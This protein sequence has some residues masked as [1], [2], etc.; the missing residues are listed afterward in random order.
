MVF[1]RTK[2]VTYVTEQMINGS[3]ESAKKRIKCY[4]TKVCILNPH[5]FEKNMNAAKI[6]LGRYLN[7]T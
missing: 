3:L 7:N 2:T 6:V 5:L 4:C 1:G